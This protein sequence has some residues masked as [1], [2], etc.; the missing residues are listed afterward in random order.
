[1]L[2]RPVP[3]VDRGAGLDGG[4]VMK[5]IKSNNLE[6]K[7]KMK[8]SMKTTFFVAVAAAI[9]IWFVA[10]V[11]SQGKSADN[12]QILRE[13]VKADKKLLVATNMNLTESEAKEFWPVYEWYQKKLTA[14]NQ[15]IGKL[16]DSY[17]A[18]YGSN[19]LTNE[20]AKKLTDELVA[21]GKA[22]AELQA[23]S[24]PKLSKVLPAKKVLRYL[25]IENKIRAA[26]KYE[27][28]ANIPLVE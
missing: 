28:A 2:K 16:I 19:T 14:I 25:Q 4:D 21:I 1:M 27:L 23:E 20:K 26:V 13:K 17:A 9:T 15:R 22:E 12:M 24:V 18:D 3:S 5:T 6:R 11:L 8:R 7:E 10:P